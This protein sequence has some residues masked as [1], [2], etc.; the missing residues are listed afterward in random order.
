VAVAIV[1][2]EPKAMEGGA[3]K[4]ISIRKAGPVRLTA[5]ACNAYTPKKP[6]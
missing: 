5:A 2:P 4:K 1:S 6:N 3:M